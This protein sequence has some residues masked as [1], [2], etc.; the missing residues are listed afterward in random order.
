MESF[1]IYKNRPSLA[2]NKYSD[3]D[4]M[5]VGLAIYHYH[6][7]KIVVVVNQTTSAVWV[8]SNNTVSL[9]VVTSYFNVVLVHEYVISRLNFSILFSI[10]LK[11]IMTDVIIMIAQII[12]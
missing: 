6:S 9:Q 11:L 2:D 4:T 10:F 5:K 8:G 3:T 1:H 12:N 7:C